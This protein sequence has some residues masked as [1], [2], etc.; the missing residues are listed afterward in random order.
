MFHWE[1]VAYFR[2]HKLSVSFHF[3]VTII[4]YLN[5][6]SVVY[7]ND[8][9]KFALEIWKHENL[10]CRKKQENVCKNLLL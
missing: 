3:N 2:F 6:E 7:P 10:C 5:N 8:F 1:Y 4:E 9:M